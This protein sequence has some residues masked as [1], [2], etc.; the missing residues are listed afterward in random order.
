MPH[1]LQLADLQNDRP[2]RAVVL[3]DKSVVMLYKVDG[4]VYCSDANST[5][6]Q[7]PLTH[8]KIVSGKHL[9]LHHCMASFPFV[10]PFQPIFWLVHSFAFLKIDVSYVMQLCMTEELHHK[11][12]IILVGALLLACAVT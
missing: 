4:K 1:C 7:Y 8:A 6:F 10:A 2:T 9:V 11:A 5:A 12:H 3:K